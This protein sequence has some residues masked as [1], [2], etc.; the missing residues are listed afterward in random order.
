METKRMIATEREA[1]MR[2]NLALN[3]LITEA[4]N[5][6]V[7]NNLV[8]RGNQLL[9]AAR[10]VGN[11]HVGEDEDLCDE[12][13]YRDG[14]GRCM[15]AL[16]RDLVEIVGELRAEVARLRSCGTCGH[17]RVCHLLWL[18]GNDGFEIS[19]PCG[20]WV[21]DCVKAEQEDGDEQTDG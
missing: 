12:C 5:L 2:V 15:T 20:H 9:A 3:F 21:E 8:R 6:K 7:R 16:I 17:R 13:A 4:E 10:C 19:K 14:G 1:L 11:V 18:Q